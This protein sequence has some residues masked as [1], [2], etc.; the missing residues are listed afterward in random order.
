MDRGRQQETSIFY[1]I[2]IDTVPGRNTGPT[3]NSLTVTAPTARNKLTDPF[4][5]SET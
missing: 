2:F 5:G 3:K 1:I 4:E